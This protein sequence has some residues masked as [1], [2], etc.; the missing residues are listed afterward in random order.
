MQISTAK[1]QLQNHL[2]MATHHVQKHDT[3]RKCVAKIKHEVFDNH[4]VPNADDDDTP[5]P[6]VNDDKIDDF[7]L[8]YY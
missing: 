6:N 7:V 8:G 2:C 5:V 4:G 1:K 3:R